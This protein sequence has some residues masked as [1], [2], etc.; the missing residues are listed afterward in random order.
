MSSW[1]PRVEDEILVV[2]TAQQDR[3]TGRTPQG[4]DDEEVSGGFLL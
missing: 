1:N 2:V 3:L 4:V